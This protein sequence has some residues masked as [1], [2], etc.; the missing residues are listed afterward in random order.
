MVVFFLLATLL[1]AAF[2]PGAAGLPLVIL[3]VTLWFFIA[4]ALSILLYCVGEQHRTQQALA[5]P[6]F[7][8][9]P[10]PAL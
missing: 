3:V 9:R 8:P 7:S 2:T 1:L 6:A 5:V 10:P 4:I